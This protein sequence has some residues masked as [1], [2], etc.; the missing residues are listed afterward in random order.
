MS[1][2]S[3]EGEHTLE[4]GS[5]KLTSLESLQPC[6]NMKTMLLEY[7]NTP[8][9][10]LLVDCPST[11]AAEIDQST[12]M[13]IIKN[14]SLREQHHSEG[15]LPLYVLPAA[16]NESQEVN[17]ASCGYQLKETQLN[18]SPVSPAMN[19]L[20]KLKER[21]D[22]GSSGSH[23]SFRKRKFKVLARK[24]THQHEAAKDD[25]RN[26]FLWILY[27]RTKAQLTSS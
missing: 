2:S 24:T 4:S 11:A 23:V 9:C 15:I 26:F 25:V 8:E 19:S 5:V 22:E 27:S 10:N 3:D 1:I 18:A 7:N 13:K 12:S 20:P 14:N 6:K 21:E 16:T 17:N